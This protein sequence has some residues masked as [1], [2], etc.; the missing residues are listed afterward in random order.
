MAPLL[1]FEW[2]D[3]LACIPLTYS[4][5]SIWTIRP[6]KCSQFQVCSMAGASDFKTL[7]QQVLFFLLKLGSKDMTDSRAVTLITR[8]QESSRKGSFQGHGIS[9]DP[10]SVCARSALSQS[11]RR[12]G[13][14]GSS[15]EGSTFSSIDNSL[16]EQMCQPPTRWKMWTMCIFFPLP[17]PLI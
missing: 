13:R 10:W 8:M 12:S 6:T 9:G 11:W 7:C 16:L 5:H 2:H 14:P 17:E 3:C 4:T 15:D 1:F